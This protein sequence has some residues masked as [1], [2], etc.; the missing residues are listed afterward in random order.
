MLLRRAY[1]K[2]TKLGYQ[3]SRS[4][5]FS[6][7]KL[8]DVAQSQLDEIKEKTKELYKTQRIHPNDVN[9]V[10]ITGKDLEKARKKYHL[11]EPNEADYAS[12]HKPGDPRRKEF[13]K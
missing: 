7:K 11:G 12:Y 9:A 6:N 3:A 2:S 5:V 1:K 8:S 13:Y 4:I 10:I